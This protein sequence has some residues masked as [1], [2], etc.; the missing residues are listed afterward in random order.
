MCRRRQCQPNACRLTIQVLVIEWMENTALEIELAECVRAATRSRVVRMVRQPSSGESGNTTFRVELCDGRCVALRTSAQSRTF[1]FTQ[2]NLLCLRSL[3]LPV[4]SVLAGGLLSG[5]GSYVI[6]SWIA[7]SDFVQEV[8]RMT[9]PELSRLARQWVQFQRQVM[10][11]PPSTGFGWAPIG[12]RAP[13]E[14]W[15]QVFGP[16]GPAASDDD[17]CLGRLRC[18]LRHVRAGLEPYFRT[19]RPL[20]FLDDLTLKNILVD[21]GALSGIIDVDFVCYGDPLLVLGGTLCEIEFEAGQNRR[22]YGQELV[23]LWAPGAMEQRALW[24]YASLCAVGRLSLTDPATHPARA[25]ALASAAGRW[26]CSAEGLATAAA[27]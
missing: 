6:L 5:G 27:A 16:G 23:R 20:C 3:G 22:F 14:Q 11:L 12:H 26:L 25:A 18:R 1:A 4:P 10:Q 15:T 19:V 21:R 7:G 24:F 17:S 2:S 13:L 9:R 8:D